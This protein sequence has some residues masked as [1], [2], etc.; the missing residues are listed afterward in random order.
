MSD[1][2]WSQAITAASTLIDAGLGGVLRWDTLSELA[3]YS[4]ERLADFQRH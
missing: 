4:C 2:L 1:E 3:L